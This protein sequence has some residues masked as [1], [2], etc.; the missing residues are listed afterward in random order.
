LTLVVH[1]F[2]DQFII[3]KGAMN[4]MLQIKNRVFNI[5]KKVL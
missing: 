2:Y 1:E 5:V 4:F 3:I